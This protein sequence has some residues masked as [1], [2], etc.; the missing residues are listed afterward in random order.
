MASN[1]KKT[2][3]SASTA[4]LPIVTDPEMAERFERELAWCVGQLECMMRSSSSTKDKDPPRSALQVL[5]N[6]KTSII[7]KRQ[8]MQQLFGD[9][10]HKMHEEDVARQ[11]RHNQIRVNTKSEI[12]LSSRFVR[13]THHNS[14]LI[15]TKDNTFSF[16]FDIPLSDMDKN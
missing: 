12:P 11:K 7:R 9:Y 8:M 1:T 2:K 10:R 13:R 16:N 6:P 14:D 3:G 15:T 4:A 5:T